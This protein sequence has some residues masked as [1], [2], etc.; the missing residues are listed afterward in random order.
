[1]RIPVHDEG[2]HDRLV[3]PGRGAQE[4]DERD[5]ALG[6]LAQPDVVRR[7]RISAHEG[8]VELVLPGVD[9]LMDLALV[10]VPDPAALPQE[11]G[12]DAQQKGHLPGFKDAALGVPKRPALTFEHKPA[13]DV[14]VA[15]N[16]IT[17]LEEADVIERGLAND[18]ITGD[19]LVS[20]HAAAQ[21]ARQYPD[22]A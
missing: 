8:V 4:I 21:R 12:A 17:A 20:R 14:T 13:A 5:L 1:M 22:R 10:V 15:E 18:G 3:A 7:R 9:L 11:Y 2:R 6:G 19:Q 16:Q